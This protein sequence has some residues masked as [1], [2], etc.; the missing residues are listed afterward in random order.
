M[1]IENSDIKSP[2]IKDFSIDPLLLVLSKIVTTVDKFSFS[3][4]LLVDGCIVYGELISK[5]EYFSKT[6]EMLSKVQN[7]DFMMLIID[8]IEEFK[9]DGIMHEHC[10]H[11]KDVVI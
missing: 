2:T 1:T 11:L 4:T 3:I 6:R 5:N 8:P 7:G 9:E 10:I